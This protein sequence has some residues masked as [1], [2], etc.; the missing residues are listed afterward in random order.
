MTA[1]RILAV[2]LALQKT[3]LAGIAGN[4]PE[5]GLV[6]TWTYDSRKKSGHDR[7][8]AIL[9]ELARAVR[10]VQPEIILLE[11]LF[12]PQAGRIGTGFVSLAMLHGVV[13]Y[14]LA[15]K[16][17]LHLVSNAHIKIYAT[18]DGRADKAAVLL[19]VERRY[20]HLTTVADDN[21]AD[22]FT[23]LALGCHYYGHPLS[24]VDGKKLPDTHLRTLTMA[25]NWPVLAGHESPVGLAA[26]PSRGSGRARKA[27]A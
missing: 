6:D 7:Q 21:Q 18:G 26:T 12:V 20:G 24:T 19:A 23:L 17:P 16:A 2:D 15:T 25:K 4:G 13:R 1:P 3:G 10:M 8:A 22:A 9:A 5:F 14:Y 11:D 27:A